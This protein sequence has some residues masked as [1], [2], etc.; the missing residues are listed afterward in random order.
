MKLMFASDIHGSA[1]Y[2]SRTLELYR[3]EQADKLIHES[4]IHFA[5]NQTEDCTCNYNGSQSRDK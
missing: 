1:L 5:E 3:L 2:C 4:C